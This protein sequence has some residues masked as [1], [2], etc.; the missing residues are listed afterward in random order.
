[1]GTSDVELR[2]APHF[3]MCT[4]NF[5]LLKDCLRTMWRFERRR[6]DLPLLT[7]L[8]TQAAQLSEISTFEGQISDAGDSQLVFASPMKVLS[9]H[10][11]RLHVPRRPRNVEL[12]KGISERIEATAWWRRVAG[13][14]AAGPLTVRERRKR[15]FG[16][17]LS[18]IPL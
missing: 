1:M 11:L 12:P 9:N 13:I 7:R 14:G 16:P 18:P 2:W 17:A 6:T 5:A 10:D 15:T 8:R 4:R 3:Q